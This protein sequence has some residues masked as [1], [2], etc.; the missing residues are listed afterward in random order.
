M[1]L[2]EKSLS[3][4][5]RIA[6]PY[7]YSELLLLVQVSCDTHGAVYEWNLLTGK[8]E[9]ECVLKTC[10]YSSI[11]LT[12]DAKIIFAV[13]SDQTLKEISESLVS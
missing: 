7:T 8:K 1:L 11:S 9:S 5:L 12:Y 10:I 2:V 4:L 6:F 13:G 3:Q